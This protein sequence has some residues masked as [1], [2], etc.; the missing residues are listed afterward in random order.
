MLDA[1]PAAETISVQ[2]SHRGVAQDYLVLPSG[3]ELTAQ[4][5]FG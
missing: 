2:G 3:G 5:K 1:A 4:M